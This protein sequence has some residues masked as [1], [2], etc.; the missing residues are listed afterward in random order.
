M[1]RVVQSGASRVLQYLPLVIYIKTA[2]AKWTVSEKL[3]RGV[4]PLKSMK[5][6]WDVGVSK[7]VRRGFPLLPDFAS[8]AFMMQGTTLDAAL[9]DL[10]NVFD[11][12]GL[13]E[14]LCA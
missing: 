11:K 5:R 9:T 12:C 2:G 4:F 7:V 10:G 8:T 1:D 3:G 14:M 13:N 6:E